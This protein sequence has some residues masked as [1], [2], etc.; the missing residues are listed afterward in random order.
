LFDGDLICVITNETMMQG[1]DQNAPIVMDIEDKVTALAEADTIENKIAY[2]LR[3]LK[4]LI[5]EISNYASAFHNKVPTNE[6]SKQEY[7]NYVNLLSVINGKAI[8]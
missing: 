7:E 1:V 2:T 8:R 4:S 6:K 5:G 3:S